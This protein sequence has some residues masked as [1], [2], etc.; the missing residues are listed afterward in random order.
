MPVKTMNYLKILWSK[1]FEPLKKESV[2]S[3]LLYESDDFIS[4]EETYHDLKR[5]GVDD[6]DLHVIAKKQG[7]ALRHGLNAA[8]FW[9][10]TNLV[11]GAIQGALIGLAAG[12][13]LAWLISASNIF[14]NFYG[15]S[16]FILTMLFSVGFGA[17]IGGFMGLQ[18]R[19]YNLRKYYKYVDEG[20]YLL[21]VD[22]RDKDV[23]LIKQEIAN[24]HP[25]LMLLDEDVKTIVP[26]EK[27]QTTH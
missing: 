10:K 1:S 5:C 26:F 24:Q 17:W 12:F 22:V 11:N 8:N 20:K 4:L 23:Q 2:M 7:K 25:R 18:S 14:E 16:G 21:L 15:T 9:Y 13:L 19:N 27:F 6:K 3:Q